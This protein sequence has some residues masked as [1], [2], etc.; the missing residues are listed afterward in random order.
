MIEIHAWKWKVKVKPPSYVRRLVTPWTAAYQAPLSMGFFR[1]E[2]WSGLPCPP[3]G[4]LSDPGIEPAFLR[5]LHWPGGRFF[6]TNATWKTLCLEYSLTKTE[7]NVLECFSS[8]F[9]MNFLQNEW[10]EL[11]IQFVCLIQFSSTYKLGY[12]EKILFSPM[13]S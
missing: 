9:K 6:T 13:Q 12:R 2:Y 8:I 1:Q 3:S 5:S 11:L 10:P 4:D 7:E